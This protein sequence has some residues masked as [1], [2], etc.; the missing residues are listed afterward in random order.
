[1][2]HGECKSTG[3]ELPARR[4]L[5]RTDAPGGDVG[6]VV[7]LRADRAAGEPAQDRDLADVREGV[8]DRDPGR[9]SPAGLRERRVEA[10]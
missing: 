10:R 9:A 6:L 1:M 8:R 2:T 7:V 3:S 4:R 5:L